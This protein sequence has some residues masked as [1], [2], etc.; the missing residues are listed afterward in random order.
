MAD[1]VTIADL[2]RAQEALE[3]AQ[4]GGAPGQRF[5]DLEQAV[6][7]LV[8]LLRQQGTSSILSRTVTDF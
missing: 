2:R 4:R 6:A 7:G 5:P 8:D 1:V 3:R